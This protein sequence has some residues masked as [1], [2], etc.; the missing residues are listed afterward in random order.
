[1]YALLIELLAKSSAE[2]GVSSTKVN[3][4]GLY[5][6]KGLDEIREFILGSGFMKHANLSSMPGRK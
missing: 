6:S 3:I 5:K 4:P 2:A 1:L